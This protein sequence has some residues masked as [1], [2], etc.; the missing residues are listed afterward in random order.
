MSNFT[1]SRWI[2]AAQKTLDVSSALVFSRLN[3]AELGK[4]VYF[5]VGARW[6]LS[7]RWSPLYR[8]GT[9]VPVLFEPDAD[10]AQRLRAALPGAIVSATA[11]S[12]HEG[13]ETLHITRMPSG[14]SL[15]EP[16]ADFG[17]G[18][19]VARR[20]MV[21]TTTLDAAARELPVPDFIKLD[22]QGAEMKILSGAASTLC[23]VLC[24]EFETRL[25]TQYRGETLFPEI[26]R[27]MRGAGFGLVA[28]RPLGLHEGEIIEGNAY[29][30]RRPSTEKDEL[31]IRLWRTVLGIPTHAQYCTL[32]G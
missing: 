30:C 23:H 28:F 17:L 10:E 1:R 31:K 6:G 25:V 19:E 7:R 13:E 11:L 15:L 29:F 4:C 14:S 18:R 27:F 5:D 16:V 2:Q 9:I 20:V 21:K 24:A 26:H 32:S 12:D 3:R 22:V 8:F